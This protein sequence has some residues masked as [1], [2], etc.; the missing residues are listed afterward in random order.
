[1][2][3]HFT[4]KQ[5]W[6]NTLWQLVSSVVLILLKSWRD[7]PKESRE[8]S[9]VNNGKVGVVGFICWCWSGFLGFGF[10]FN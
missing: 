1:M 7:H 3:H 5:S 6:V 10:V 4:L 9:K 2:N 8:A